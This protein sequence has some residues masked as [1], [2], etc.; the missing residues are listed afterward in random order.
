MQLVR[1]DELVAG[2]GLLAV[3]AAPALP[4]FSSERCRQGVRKTAYLD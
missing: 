1:E 2:L 3:S 4:D